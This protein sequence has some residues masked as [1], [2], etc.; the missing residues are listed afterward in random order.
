MIAALCRRPRGHDQEDAGW[1]I[2]G[3]KLGRPV[4]VVRLVERID[5]QEERFGHV[6]G[7]GDDAEEPFDE[8]R[9]FLVVVRQLVAGGDATSELFGEVV[10][11]HLGGGDA[12]VAVAEVVA[13]RLSGAVGPVGKE[14]GLADAGVSD[15]D[16]DATA[17]AAGGGVLVEA[18]PHEIAADEVGMV[19]GA[20]SGVA[21]EA[22]LFVPVGRQQRDQARRRRRRLLLTAFG[23]LPEPVCVAAGHLAEQSQDAAKGRNV[24][25]G[26]AALGLP[27]CRG[28]CLRSGSEP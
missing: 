26:R 16:E 11:G 24:H 17:S 27:L 14:G 2:L 10:A 4:G 20:V 21:E 7:L 13:E 19:F 5:E 1:Q 15:E 23:R 9:Q 18:S 6:S 28:F 22:G 25:R 8:A 3:Q 12:V